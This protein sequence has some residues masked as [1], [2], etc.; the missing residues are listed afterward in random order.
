MKKVKVYNIKKLVES[1][2]PDN[3]FPGYYRGLGILVGDKGILL[4]DS[5]SNVIMGFSIEDELKFKLIDKLN[6]NAISANTEYVIDI[7]IKKLMTAE[8]E[9]K[10]LI[11]YVVKF[12]TFDKVLRG[13]EDI[14]LNVEDYFDLNDKR[15]SD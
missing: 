10:L 9:E 5:L 14:G 7:T 3:E 2:Y 11:D 6:I 13:I 8:C 4:F 15:F 1:S 12:E